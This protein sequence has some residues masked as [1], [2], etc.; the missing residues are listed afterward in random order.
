MTIPALDFAHPTTPRPRHRTA[1]E[2][3]RQAEEWELFTCPSCI[4]ADPRRRV[5]LLR[6]RAAPRTRFWIFDDKDEEGT[7]QAH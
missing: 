5:I 3:Q 4:A 2:F 6:R 7:P 1:A